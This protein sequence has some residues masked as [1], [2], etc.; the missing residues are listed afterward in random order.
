[1]YNIQK[2]EDRNIEGNYKKIEYCDR[3][4]PP[5]VSKSIYK[6]YRVFAIIVKQWEKWYCI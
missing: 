4:T 1:M 5:N 6:G 2:L 3:E